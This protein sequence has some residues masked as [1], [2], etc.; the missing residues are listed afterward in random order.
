MI[1]VAYLLPQP[2][3]LDR[4]DVAPEG[5]RSDGGRC[6]QRA[7][8]PRLAQYPGEDASEARSRSG[9]HVLHKPRLQGTVSVLPVFGG[10]QPP[11]DGRGEVVRNVADNHVPLEGHRQRIRVGDD[12]AGHPGLQPALK[13]L[14]G[15]GIDVDGEQL[16]SQPGKWHGQRTP[17]RANLSNA[18][19]EPR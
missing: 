18:A 12:D 13:P 3:P 16:P 2:C 8:P 1:L 5:F 7:R 4:R 9:E 14:H 10:K 15:A 6:Q 17:A 11:Q 19:L